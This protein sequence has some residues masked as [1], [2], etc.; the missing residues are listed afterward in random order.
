MKTSRTGWLILT[1]A[2][3]L[4]WAG[5]ATG[6]PTPEQRC[7][8][9]RY[10]AAGK[11]ASCQQ[12]ALGKFHARGDSSKFDLATRK[13]TVKYAKTWT[14]LSAIGVAP[15]NGDRFDDAAADGTVTDK[16]TGLQWEQKTDDGT[17]HD[18][19][20]FYSWSV[21]GT[22]ADGTA[23]TSFLSAL[24]DPAETCFAGQC[25][26]R[27]PTLTE[28][29]SIRVLSDSNLLYPCIE[30][31]CIDQATFGAT[32]SNL[33]WSATTHAGIPTLG[34]TVDFDDGSVTLYSKTPFYVRA[35]RG[36]L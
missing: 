21:S 31:P 8:Q 27:L 33:Y 17:V 14:K 35:V 18:K 4:G 10:I 6:A 30:S 23:F 29:E 1:A 25:D 11:Y 32:Q 7:H 28:L 20:N 26:W 2:L 15:C 16:L 19:D 13:C 5:I 12:Q 22:V 9:Q 34:W 3:L 24:N 36:G